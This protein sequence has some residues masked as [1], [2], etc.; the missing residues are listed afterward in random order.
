MLNT[1]E[2]DRIE[3]A[4]QA[5][6]TGTSGEIVCLLA[7]EVSAYRE[8]PLA[9]AAAA[10]LVIPP[11]ALVLGLRPLALAAQ[12]GVWTAAQ[13]S[14]VE[15][16]L[17]LGLTVFV[18]IQAALFIAV[19][20]IVHIPAVRRLLT[21][22]ALKRHRVARAAYHQFAAFG[23]RAIGS[24]TGV[25]IFVALDD[26]QVQVLADGAINAK[27]GAGIW[28]RAAKAVSAAMKAR[29][30]PTA[31]ILEAVA[32]CGDALK[33]HFPSDAPHADVYSNRPVEL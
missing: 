16:Q 27:T 2:K 25:M 31:G 15:S 5:A 28:D 21:P 19:Y 26:H 12:A 8:V 6:E 11:L 17:A 1:L 32:I 30:D 24:A 13:T 3:A 29:H 20:L 9:W 18:A 14:A 4:I 33:T 22:A 10:A 23:A 7:Q